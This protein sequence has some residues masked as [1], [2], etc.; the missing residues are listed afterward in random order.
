M[1]RL[2]QK[3]K[4]ILFVVPRVK[5]LFGDEVALTVHPHVGVAYLA[6]FLKEKGI[7][8][9]VYDE[10][11]DLSRSKLMEQIEEFKPDLIGI[12]IFSYCYAFADSLIKIIKSK[13]NI[14]IIAGGPHVSVAKKRMLERSYVDFAIKNEGELALLELIGEMDK[15]QPDFSLI[16]GLIWRDKENN[17]VENPDRPYIQD[18]DSMPFPDY[19]SFGIE[20][21]ACYKEKVLPLITS[22]GCPFACNYCSVR[23]TMGLRFRA[24]SAKNV[25]SEL[26]YFYKRGWNS[27]E[28][29][30][31]CFTLDKQRVEKIC[32]LIIANRLKIKFQLYN[33]IRVD[34][35][36]LELLK[37]LKQA[38]CYFIAFGCE[39]GTDK[40][41]KAIKKS[42]TLGQVINAVHWAN[43]AGINNAVNFI[44]GH[45]QETYQDAL[46]TI[47]FA[48]SLPTDLVNFC[49]LMP[50][51]GTESYQW[52]KE[53]ARFLVPSDSFLE[54]IS[55][56]D[57]IPVFETDEFTKE[58][59]QSV[60][61][62]G[63]KLYR[64]KILKFRLG[65]ILGNLTYLAT[66]NETVNKYAMRFALSNPFGRFIYTTLSKKSFNAK[67]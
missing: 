33:G 62:L 67:S 7:E 3:K 66:N 25:F 6:S 10:G 24:R 32:D 61:S 38:G 16:Q 28:I 54:E 27:F 29:N 1:D 23:L 15:N 5:S 20:Q 59:R 63:F 56:R 31:D 43:E 55:Y 48:K 30:D 26:D 40:V 64:R 34:T 41:L 45:K 44:I 52:A 65:K 21:Y 4:R 46:Q 57:N 49:N 9:S 8:V 42:I 60:I 39:A 35:V 12:T 22:R 18:L 2:F 19:D 11:L 51:P 47:D 53:H 14:P 58:Q 36:D 37:K 17:I 13:C 50:Y